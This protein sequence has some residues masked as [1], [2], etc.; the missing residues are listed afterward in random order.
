MLVLLAYA[1]SLGTGM[2]LFMLVLCSYMYDKL[3]DYACDRHSTY[4]ALGHMQQHIAFWSESA[5]I[6]CGCCLQHLF[7][8]C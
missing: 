2:M 8:V 5:C 3:C 7:Q 4:V 6:C 1:S